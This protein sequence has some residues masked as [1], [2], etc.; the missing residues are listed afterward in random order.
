MLLPVSKQSKPIPNYT[1]HCVD[2]NMNKY[3]TV[4]IVQKSNRE[5]VERDKHIYIDLQP[6]GINTSILL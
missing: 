1:S 6:S 4:V 2:N 3:Y 5:I